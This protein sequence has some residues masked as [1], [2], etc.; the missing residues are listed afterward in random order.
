MPTPEGR[1]AEVFNA[2]FA[3][4]DI[5]IEPKD[6]T[7]GTHRRIGHQGWRITYRIDP[8]DAGFPS[9][10]FYATHWMTDD[11]HVRIWADGALERLDAIREFFGYDSTVPGSKETAEDTYLRHNR[12]IARQLRA[13][14]LY[15]YDDINAY[16]RTGGAEFDEG[17]SVRMEDEEPGVMSFSRESAG[18][19][20]R[21]SPAP[22][23]REGK[24]RIVTWNMGFNDYAYRPRHDEAWRFL[25]DELQ[26][27]LALVQEAIVP[28]WAQR[29]FRVADGKAFVGGTWGSAV[30]SVNPVEKLL[31]TWE[32]GSVVAARVDA[33]PVP[34]VAVSL[35]AR[36][37]EE[38]VIRH[39][40]ET[41]SSLESVLRPPFVVG[42]DFNT[43]RS[44]AERYGPA[45]G[46]GPFWENLDREFWDCHWNI[47]ASR[48]R[49][50]GAARVAGT[51]FRTTHP[52]RPCDR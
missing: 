36:V 26:P 12:A 3:N 25:V 44:A 13:R 6:V 48:R 4:F 33:W 43:F 11:R 19:G 29:Q 49:P 2:C 20:V 18:T 45:Y 8:D 17:S 52:H 39:L 27:D 47:R 34:L 40:T 10:E 38:G 51:S 15:P 23:N 41:F 50:F 28:E 9:L 30:L 46:H 24:M 1:V 35:Q 5:R 21:V 32:R 31:A 16:L 37:F 14:G 42:G 22:V 7:V